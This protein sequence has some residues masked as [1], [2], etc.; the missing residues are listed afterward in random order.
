MVPSSK[1]LPFPMASTSPSWGFS[2]AESGIYRP[3]RRASPFSS[4]RLI[5]T[6]SYN[7]RI[8]IS[9]G[10]PDLLV[11]NNDGIE[12]HS[13]RVNLAISWFP[14]RVPHLLNDVLECDPRQTVLDGGFGH[15]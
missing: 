2:F 15:R 7:G 1:R 14:H 4:T 11:L 8:F 5:T 6:R 13:N 10:L 9:S 3:P 12:F